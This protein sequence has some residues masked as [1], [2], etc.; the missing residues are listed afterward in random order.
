MPGPAWPGGDLQ[1]DHSGVVAKPADELSA[2]HVDVLDLSGNPTAL[3]ADN[4]R[5]S[6]LLGRQIRAAG[7]AASD[8]AGW[9]VVV[10]D[11]QNLSTSVG[12]ECVSRVVG[13][14]ER[15]ARPSRPTDL[16]HDLRNLRTAGDLPE[17]TARVDTRT[18]MCAQVRSDLP[19]HRPET[20]KTRP[21]PFRQATSGGQAQVDPPANRS[22]LRPLLRALGAA[23]DSKEASIRAT[24]IRT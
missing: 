24:T 12:L 14:T 6:S 5:S 21:T 10:Q 22:P 2:S 4:L 15:I 20:T 11:L 19:S 17:P 3:A 16:D 13:Q 18:H 23:L 1:V 7:R 9:V 8:D